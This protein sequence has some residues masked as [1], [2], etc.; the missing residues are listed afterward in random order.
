[1]LPI[2]PLDLLRCSFYLLLHKEPLVYSIGVT[3]YDI[4]E[5]QPRSNIYLYWPTT[6]TI[7]AQMNLAKEAGYDRLQT[8][9][10]LEHRLN[11]GI[12]K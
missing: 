6:Q 9:R 5:Q 11:L 12:T 2:P 4:A 3:I 1:M 10:Y 7:V 8:I